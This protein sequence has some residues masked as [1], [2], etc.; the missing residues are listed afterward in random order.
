[1]HATR[2]YFGCELRETLNFDLFTSHIGPR[3]LRLHCKPVHYIHLNFYDF[4]IP[5][6]QAR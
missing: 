4:P 5:V 2:Q 6:F 3:E 1:M